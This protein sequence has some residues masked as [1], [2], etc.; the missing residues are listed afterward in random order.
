MMDTLSRPIRRFAALGLLLAVL[1][2]LCGFI[3]LPLFSAWTNNQSHIAQERERLAQLKATLARSYRIN[4]TELERHRQYLHALQVTGR[5]EA[6]QLAVLQETLRKLADKSDVR[7]QSLRA[8]A[9]TERNSM[10]LIGAQFTVT[11]SLQKAQRLILEVEA[12]R[13][14]M[15]IERLELSPLPVR[16]DQRGASTEVHLS[17]RLSAPITS[18]DLAGGSRP[19]EISR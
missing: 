17:V 15:F 16:D 18:A 9:T 6:Q 14:F 8:L 4:P 10:R 1:L 2:A 3:L 5:T 11:A 12:A 19:Q 13:P 7:F